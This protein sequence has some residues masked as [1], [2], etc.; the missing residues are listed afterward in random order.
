MWI[1]AVVFLCRTSFALMKTTYHIVKCLASYYTLLDEDLWINSSEYAG[2]QCGDLNGNQ[3][4]T[5]KGLIINVGW[6]S[7]F[8]SACTRGGLC[9]FQSFPPYHHSPPTS[10]VLCLNVKESLCGWLGGGYA[11]LEGKYYWPCACSPSS[12]GGDISRWLRKSNSSIVVIVYWFNSAA[13]FIAH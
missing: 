10:H 4:F 2:V 6:H 3:R 9:W 7:N 11:G 8:P 1:W 12:N 5:T 13:F